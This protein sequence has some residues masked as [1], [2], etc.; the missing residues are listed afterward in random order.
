MEKKTI[1][2]RIV[3]NTVLVVLFVVSAAFIWYSRDY[4]AMNPWDSYNY[5]YEATRIDV[6]DDGKIYARPS[7]AQELWKINLNNEIERQ[8]NFTELPLNA[9]IEQF[10]ID[11]AGNIYTVEIYPAGR[12][13]E[14]TG[15]G[16]KEYANDGT[17]LATIAEFD[18]KTEAANSLVV[19]PINFLQFKNG[20]LYFGEQTAKALVVS[21]YEPGGVQQVLTV[22]LTA[23]QLSDVEDFEYLPETATLIISRKNGQMRYRA[24]NGSETVANGG[25][26]GEI[27][28]NINGDGQGGLY[29]ADLDSNRI[30][31]INP[32]GSGRR[33]VLDLNSQ[34]ALVD[35]DW[36]DEIL[37]NFTVGGAGALCVNGR[38]NLLLITPDGVQTALPAVAVLANKLRLYLLSIWL[39]AL[40]G[41]LI[42]LYF[43]AK[44]LRFVVRYPTELAKVMFYLFIIAAAGVMA[45]KLA[46]DNIMRDYEKTL[47]K[48]NQQLAV[49]AARVFDTEALKAINGKLDYD[50]PEFKLLQQDADDIFRPAGDKNQSIDRSFVL[51]KPVDTKMRLV[52]SNHW[53]SLWQPLPRN[54]STEG[55]YQLAEKKTVESWTENFGKKAFIVSYAPVIDGADKIIGSVEVRYDLSNVHT[56]LR[57]QFWRDLVGIIFLLVTFHL[58]IVELNQLLGAWKRSREIGQPLSDN[59]SIVRLLSFLTYMAVSMSLLFCAARIAQFDQTGLA[60]PKELVMALPFAV[61]MLSVVTLNLFLAGY[62]DRWGW[63]PQMVVGVI[64][65]IVGCVLT[66]GAVSLPLFLLGRVFNGAAFAVQV[67][68]LKAFVV[69]EQ[70]PHQRKI[71]SA[72]RTTGRFAGGLCGITIG[73][74]VATYSTLQATFLCSAVIAVVLL[75]AVCLLTKNRRFE[76]TEHDKV[77]TIQAFIILLREPRMLF[78][79]VLVFF[80]LYFLDGFNSYLVPVVVKNLQLDSDYIGY[81]SFIVYLCCSYFSKPLALNLSRKLP[82][83]GCI[84]IGMG[85]YLTATVVLQLTGTLGG[86]ILASMIFGIGIS[87]NGGLITEMFL[88]SYVTKRMGNNNMNNVCGI[89]FALKG[90]LG[91]VLLGVCWKFGAGNGIL[92]YCGGALVLTAIYLS[93]FRKGITRE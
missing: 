54:E 32:Q 22:P 47:T 10:A 18:N 27:N 65:M 91:P 57:L 88:H 64:L 51:Y 40:A 2:R 9:F 33:V 59:L 56:E 75:L 42:A 36:A 60:L 6:G 81:A 46:N 62:M 74:L 37:R 70:D 19:S 84:L 12:E 79:L 8:I 92:L 7:S 89:L 38:K 76:T 86:I 72:E 3:L 58:I 5:G 68:A 23:Q 82:L 73:T 20:V 48:E 80:P 69:C 83:Y 71:G 77:S 55:Y 26:P 11:K 17:L 78:F 66:W 1:S 16:I 43:V 53:R 63:K 24:A 61:E 35:M 31:N 21:K 30:F 25:W 85:L 39:A 45:A 29:Y 44:L 50:K 4:L 67:N 15:Y 49:I 28:W 52:V 87:I 41:L 93:L 14:R 90:G 34:A 13:D